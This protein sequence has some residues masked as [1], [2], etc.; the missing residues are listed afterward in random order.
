[1]REEYILEIGVIGVG[2]V[3]G[4]F[5]G[6]LAKA[7]EGN[8][9]VR[10]N[11]V[12]RGKHYKE[13]L[14]NGLLLDTEQGEFVCKPAYI[15]DSITKLPILDAILICVKVYDLAKVLM[16]LQ[17]KITNQ[18]IILPLLNGVDIYQRI[19]NVLS[20]PFVLP[21]C[22]YV[23]THIERPGKVTQRG[24]ACTIHLGDDPEKSKVESWF[25]D[26]LKKGNIQFNYTSNPYEEIWSKF[27]F[28]AS[29]GL[30]TANY[31]KT[32]GEIIKDPELSKIVLAIMAEI[33]SL[34]KIQGISLPDKIIED[35]FEKGKKFP[36][37]TKTSFQ[38]DFEI[39]DKKDERDL[40]GGAILRMGEKFNIDTKTTKLIYNSLI[41]KKRM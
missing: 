36:F 2:G 33:Y 20:E 24:G 30:V 35:S 7:F 34:A 41:I 3:G 40:F 9:K 23:G 12:A 13:I 5:G 27:I 4:Y 8:K 14:A 37:E 39:S 17:D 6:K 25:L 10:I 31:N 38:R 26:L 21:S 11:F 15:T 1:M 16:D 28:I 18:T 22:V 19:K 32:I 29:Y